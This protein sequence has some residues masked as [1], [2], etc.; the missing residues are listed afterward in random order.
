MQEDDPFDPFCR[1]VEQIAEGE[2]AGVVDQDVDVDPFAPGE[3]VQLSGGADACQVDGDGADPDAGCGALDLPADRFERFR[4]VSGQHEVVSK[5]R[6]PQRVAAPDARSGARY[7]G[8]GRARLHGAAFAACRMVSG[9]HQ[10]RRLSS[11]TILRGRSGQCLQHFMST[12][13]MRAMQ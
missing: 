10:G 6:Q 9:I 3:I 1:G 13:Y 2:D 12:E 5:G 7:E 8:P 4:P 11:L